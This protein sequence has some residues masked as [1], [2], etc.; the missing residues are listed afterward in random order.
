VFEN[1]RNYNDEIIFKKFL[2]RKNFNKKEH[3]KQEYKP[4]EEMQQPNFNFMPQPLNRN[5]LIPNKSMINQ[6]P[7]YPMDHHP[8]SSRHLNTMILSNNIPSPMILNTNSPSIMNHYHQSPMIKPQF[9][10][11]CGNNNHLYINTVVP[12]TIHY[13]PQYSIHPKKK[14][15]NDPFALLRTAGNSTDDESNRINLESVTFI[16]LDFTR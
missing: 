6:L 12:Q 3:Y 1:Q 16:N 13:S 7:G 11:N 15:K 8:R 14:K 9:S 10:C 4:M 2:E 5:Y